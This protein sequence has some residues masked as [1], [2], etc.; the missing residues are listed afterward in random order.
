MNGKPAF[1]HGGNLYKASRMNCLSFDE[2][3]DFS[4]NINPLGLAPSI[5]KVLKT[6][7]EHVIH[8]PDAEAK[9]LKEAISQHYGV[10]EEYIT[11]GNGAVEIL[12]ILCHMLKPKHVLIPAPAFSEYE[13][14]AKSVGAT[15]HYFYTHAHDEFLLN[16]NQ[17]ISKIAA[18]DIL[19]LGNPNN[20]T[21]TLLLRENI[22]YLLK[23]ASVH[24]TLV[25]VDESFLDFL[26]DDRPFT[27]RHL[28]SRYSNLIVL[29][30]L[31]KFYAIPGLRLG[32]SLANETLTQLFH[33]GKDP[34]NVNVLAQ[35]AGI[36][37]L[38]DRQYQTAS[39]TYIEQVKTVLYSQLQTIPKV[40]PYPPAVNFILVNIEETGM[41]AKQLCELMTTYHI[42]IRDCSN[43][44]GLS[45]GYIRLAVKRSDQNATLLQALKEIIEGVKND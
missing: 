32:F 13:R 15:V 44:P 45:S 28:I 38:N 23:A 2:L 40:R 43:Y 22:E 37:A 36:A 34:W 27:C 9:T 39:K 20:P 18:V 17:L 11:A 30:S 21:G 24:N 7:L 42:L 4:A 10:N 33:S 29:H 1:E 26:T 5:K 41:K 35:S 12:Y 8:Y 19:F 6:D 25:V 14:S 31:T 16:I 3:L